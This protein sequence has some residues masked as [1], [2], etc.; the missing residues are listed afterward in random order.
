MFYPF[1][2]FILFFIF[3]IF[4]YYFI[5]SP[6]FCFELD[7]NKFYKAVLFTSDKDNEINIGTNATINVNNP[8][9]NAGISKQ[10]I[11]SIAAA[12]SSA[13]GATVGVKS[14]QYIRG[15]LPVKI[16]A[17][18]GT[19]A[20]VQLSAFVFFSGL[21][22]QS[23]STNNIKNFALD[24]ISDFNNNILSSDPLDLLPQ[25][26][27]FLGWAIVF[28]FII[29]CIYVA[30]Y[31]ASFDYSKYIPNNKVVN[32]LLNRYIKMSS[33]TS[34]Y[35]LIFSYI[36]LSLSLF[37]CIFTLFIVF[38]NIP[39]DIFNC[40]PLELLPALN[41]LLYCAILS[42]YIIIKISV[43]KYVVNL[44][45]KKYIPKNKFG[46]VLNRILG[47]LID[48]FSKP[49]KYLLIFFYVMI[50]LSLFMCKFILFLVF[51]SYL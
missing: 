25:V 24:I 38:N 11:Y 19:I 32:Y 33:N 39:V 7:F 48:R 46:E 40:Y 43:A 16:V 3:F 9:L 45:Y 44:N 10:G 8:N 29:I 28:I 26:N 21:D 49:S 15:P 47:R 18:L 6:Y 23:R 5:F 2:K 30:R 36:M 22:L 27:I 13:G 17:G 34:R 51:N 42:L 41:G 35:L 4:F 14:A 20:F 50:P 12:L 31:G 1:I 37:M